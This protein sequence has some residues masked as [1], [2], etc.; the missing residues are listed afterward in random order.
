MYE[1]LRRCKYSELYFLREAIST[2]LNATP[3][4]QHRAP[5]DVAELADA[6]QSPHKTV[7]LVVQHSTGC[8]CTTHFVGS[9]VLTG[10]LKSKLHKKSSK[11]TC[12]LY[13]LIGLPKGRNSFNG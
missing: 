12:T 2:G 9:N 11:L 1:W 6:T 4:T 10:M 5:I 13:V 8:N 3:E 7:A